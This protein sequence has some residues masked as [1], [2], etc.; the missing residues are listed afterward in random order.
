MRRQRELLAMVYS[1]SRARRGS[2]CALVRR[3]TTRVSRRGAAACAKTKPGFR[4]TGQRKGACRM[5]G[6]LV[7]ALVAAAVLMVPAASQAQTDD[8]RILSI[9]R[10]IDGS[11]NNLAHPTW[12]Q[13]GVQ[14]LRVAPANYADGFKTPV[15]GPATRYV[16]N[17]IFNDVAQNLFSERNVT[18]WGFV[19]GQ[20]MDHTFGLRVE[21]GGESA[22]IAFQDKLH[23]PIEE[24]TNAF[25][26]IDFSRTPAAPGTGVRG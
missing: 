21:N 17:R 10:S 7:M 25:G 16:S 5:R 19:W 12:G 2:Q 18:Q 20:F 13:A 22:P 15:A 3:L 9:V 6:K 11:G 14:Y 1:N 8:T 26:R 23:D 24:F 4:A